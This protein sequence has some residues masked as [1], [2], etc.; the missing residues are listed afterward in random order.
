MSEHA[1]VAVPYSPGTILHF[2]FMIPEFASV[3]LCSLYKL[4]LL[5]ELFDQEL[6][7]QLGWHYFLGRITVLTPPPPPPFS[8]TLSHFENV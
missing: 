7:L 4:D 1:A 8:L 6:L 2:S 3:S 5:D